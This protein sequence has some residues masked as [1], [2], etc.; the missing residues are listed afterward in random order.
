MAGEGTAY[1]LRR[2]RIITANGE[3]G[4]YVVFMS[5]THTWVLVHCVFSTQGRLDLIPDV[6]EMCKYLTGVA[7]AK[8]ITLLA[9]GGTANHIHLLVAQP[10]TVTLAKV[11]QDLK[12]NSS[13]WMNKRGTKFAWQEGFGGFRAYP[14]LKHWALICRPSGPAASSPLLEKSG[15]KIDNERVFG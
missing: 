3:R 5:H 11:M 6:T 9:A 14:V 1:K 8:N 2:V 12:G 15:A 13:R 7:H 10:S 4:G